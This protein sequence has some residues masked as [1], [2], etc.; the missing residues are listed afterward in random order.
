MSQ[1]R[2]RLIVPTTSKCW[3]TI[4]SVR[5]CPIGPPSSSSA[6]PPGRFRFTPTTPPHFTWSGLPQHSTRS[7]LLTIAG[8]RL[9]AF[10]RRFSTSSAV[11]KTRTMPS[12]A[13]SASA[14]TRNA[15]RHSPVKPGGWPTRTSS[16]MPWTPPARRCDLPRPTATRGGSSPRSPLLE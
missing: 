1:R 13:W 9:P 10:T 14:A 11:A 12:L 8:L 4:T 15:R 16:R 5:A 3:P 6:P 7:G 2:W